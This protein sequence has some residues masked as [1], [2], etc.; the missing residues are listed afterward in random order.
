MYLVDHELFMMIFTLKI[1]ELQNTLQKEHLSSHG[2]FS[3]ALSNLNEIKIFITKW[4]MTGENIWIWLLKFNLKKKI[5]I[6]RSKL[7]KTTIS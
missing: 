7:L 5:V 6:F 2:S 4:N 3:D 1:E